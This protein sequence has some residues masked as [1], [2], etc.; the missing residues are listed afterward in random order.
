MNSWVNLLLAL[1]SKEHQVEDKFLWQSNNSF[2]KIMTLHEKLK[3]LG[4]TKKTKKNNQKPKKIIK[5]LH[6]NQKKQ[7]IL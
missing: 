4:K 2:R 3:N 7:K 5:Q 1:T 6:K